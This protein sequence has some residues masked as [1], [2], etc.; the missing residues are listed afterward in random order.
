MISDM[1]LLEP[2]PSSLCEGVSR[3]RFFQWSFTRAGI[4]DKFISN[5]F[6]REV[7]K[8]LEILH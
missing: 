6:T 5:F 8:I 7:R 4:K 3:D 2:R 1:Y